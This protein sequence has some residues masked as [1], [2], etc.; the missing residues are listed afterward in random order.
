MLS[1]EIPIC[2]NFAWWAQ[3][4][5]FCGKIFE[6]SIMSMNL[7]LIQLSDFSRLRL[8]KYLKV[9]RSNKAGRNAIT[10]PPKLHSKSLPILKKKYDDDAFARFHRSCISF[11]L[12]KPALGCQIGGFIF[13]TTKKIF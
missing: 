12:Q 3:K 2:K 5:L 6:R 10:D 7:A 11:V 4:C 1:A 8:E 9:D 13:Q